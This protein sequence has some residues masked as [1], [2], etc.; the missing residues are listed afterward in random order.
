MPRKILLAGLLCL[1][2]ASLAGAADEKKP[3]QA[4]T[5]AVAKGKNV[6]VLIE[7]TMGNIK[8]ELYP[9]KAPKTVENFLAYANSGFYTDTIF[10]RVIPGFMIQGGGFTK[11]M[12]QKQAKAP[13]ALESQNGLKNVRGAIAMARTSDPNSATSQFFINVKDNA[14][15]DYP[16]PDGNGYAVF[17]KVLEGM[18]VAD[19]IV[20]VATTEKGPYRDVPVDPIVIKSVKV[21][22]P[23]SK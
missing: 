2:T 10:H 21:I 12:D 8:L 20:G 15:L 4:S 13:I 19:K 14:N 22:A 5:P 1:L 3:T 16:K 17:G 11:S 7:T 9:D 23:A 6:V 18:D